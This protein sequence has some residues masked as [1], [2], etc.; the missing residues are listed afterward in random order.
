MVDRMDGPT[1]DHLVVHWVV[2]MA[3]LW[4]LRKVVH[5]VDQMDYLLVVVMMV[6]KY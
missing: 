3:A 2:Q 4:A 1:A 6:E 5:L